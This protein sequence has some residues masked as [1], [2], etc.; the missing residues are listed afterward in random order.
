[1][2]VAAPPGL[3]IAAPRSGSGKTTL[4][5]GLMRAARQ[6]GRR[7]LGAK[8]GPDYIDPA[9]H[10]AATG[11]PGLNLDSW[12]MEP[13][14]R[15]ALVAGVAQEG[16]LILCEGLMGLFDGVPAEQGRSGSSADI[17]AAFGWPVILILDVSGQSQSAA[18]TAL[19]CATLDPR[20]TIAGV[21]LNRIGSVRHQMLATQAIESVGLPV[22]GALRRAPEITLPERHLGL[23]QAGETA[24]LD[25]TLDRLAGFIETQIDVDRLLSLAVPSRVEDFA[26]ALPLKPP[27]QRLAIARDA[28]FSFLYPHLLQGW[29]AAG[30]ELSFF[31]PLADESPPPDCDFCWLPGG[32]PELYAGKIA[33]ATHFLGGTRRFAESRPIHGECGGYMVLGRGLIDA[34]GAKHQMLGLLGLSTSFEKRRLTLGYREAELLADTALGLRGEKLRGHE[35]HYATIADKGDD[36]PLVILNDAYGS[37]PSLAGSVRAQVSGSFFHII[38]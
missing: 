13:S 30:A 32:Y 2:S 26:S 31:S 23:V 22:L 34:S 9:F 7:V 6:R 1:M 12:A 36:A 14:L 8:C 15:H 5:L 27:G 24:E 3:L 4:T 18:A 20:L 16:D 25:L 10:A 35:F 38:A 19:G 33:A 11:R 17:A 28:A 21:V 29:R 37:T